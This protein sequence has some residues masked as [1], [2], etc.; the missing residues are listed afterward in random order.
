MDYNNLPLN[1]TF[2]KLF[3]IALNAQ[4]TVVEHWDR[5]L[6][7]WSVVSRRS[8]KDEELA[9]FQNLIGLLSGRNVAN[10]PDKRL[11]SLKSGGVFWVKSLVSHLK[12]SSPLEKRLEKAIWKTKSP[13]RVNIF[14]WILLFGALNCS[15]IL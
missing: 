15:E 5:T 2:P 1:L 6:N 4:R 8:L 3:K 14:I 12:I 9:E 11:W 7:S 13:R 10:F